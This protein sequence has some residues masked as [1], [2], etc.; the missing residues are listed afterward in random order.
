[1]QTP[2]AKRTNWFQ[3]LY[4]SLYYTGTFLLLFPIFLSIPNETK[5]LIVTYSIMT[6]ALGMIITQLYI[7]GSKRLSETYAVNGMMSYLLSLLQFLGPVIMILVSLIYA[8]Y[9]FA[10]YGDIIDDRRTSEQYY[11]F[12]KFSLIFTIIL[13]GILFGGIGSTRFKE[14]GYLPISF[15]SGIMLFGV[16]NAYFLIIMGYILSSYTTDG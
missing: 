13:F 2:P 15:T 3:V 5:M 6:I 9:L 12:S 8:I 16:L 11:S 4:T 14:E 1:M 7:R 10:R